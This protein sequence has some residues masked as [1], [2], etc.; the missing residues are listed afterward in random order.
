MFIEPK[1][2]IILVNYNGDKDTI[3]CVKSLLQIDYSNFEIIIVDNASATQQELEKMLPSEVVYIKSNENLGFSGGNNLG[4]KYAIKNN[5][6]YVL[7]LNNDT[8]VDKSFLKALV[9]AAQKHI[10]AGIITGKILYYDKPDYVWYAG[11]Y[12]NLN[13]ARIHHDHIQEKDDFPDDDRIVSFAT[14]C[15]MM[16]PQNIIRE[17]G[18]L[19]DAFFMYSE[20]AEFCSRIQNVERKILYTPKAKIYHKV[21]SSSGGAGSKL[22]QYYRARNELYLTFHYAEHKI[23]GCFWCLIRYLKRIAVGQFSVRC[24]IDGI[25]DFCSGKM[26]KTDRTL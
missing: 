4:I 20:D 2:D 26:G 8:V 18:M 13:R 9:E 11:G 23:M 5:A 16:M 15:L 19:N 22:S 7:L 12:M 17:V 10:D 1:V 6:D 24:T 3:D 25:H 21:S 14:G